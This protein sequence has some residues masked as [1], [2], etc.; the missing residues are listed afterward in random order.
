[1]DKVSPLL[2][3][4]GFV[5]YLPPCVFFVS[6]KF[7]IFLYPSTRPS[8]ISVSLWD[9]FL[10]LL[11]YASVWFPQYVVNPPPFSGHDL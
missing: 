1:M 2:S 7:H 5:P 9:L 8:F 3:V 6:E 10:C 4:L 11:C